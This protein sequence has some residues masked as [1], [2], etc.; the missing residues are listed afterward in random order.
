LTSMRAEVVVRCFKHNGAVYFE[1]SLT[2]LVG[3][4]PVSVLH[5]PYPFLGGRERRR[6]G[7]VE[8]QAGSAALARA[9]RSSGSA[10]G[11]AGE[12][13]GKRRLPVGS[14]GPAVTSMPTSQ[15]VGASASFLSTNHSATNCSP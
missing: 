12:L 10:G 13:E 7:W 3:F 2:V 14:T 8:H 5:P 9:I 15:H 6:E 4:S 11:L 1:E